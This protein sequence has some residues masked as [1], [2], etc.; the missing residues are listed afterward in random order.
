[1]VVISILVLF[2]VFLLMHLY[3]RHGKA[4]TVPELKGL[5]FEEAI[6]KLDDAGLNY[7]V[8]EAGSRVKPRRII[9]L[10]INAFYPRTI[11][12][13]EVEG[14]SA[15]HANALLEGL[16]FTNIGLKRVDGKYNGLVVGIAN[17]KGQLI[18]P[19]TKVTIKAHLT[20]LVT[21]DALSFSADSL[22]IEES[23]FAIP[24][25]D[26][27]SATPQSE[28]DTREVAPIKDDEPEEWW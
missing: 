20:L 1:M 27:D 23:L 6:E 16:G 13:P 21:S 8:V 24:S 11:A 19:G 2:V 17:E 22:A 3:T 10:T 9:F 18:P 25:G 5:S 26:D 15:R 14:Q 7:E 4:V 12:I 28:I